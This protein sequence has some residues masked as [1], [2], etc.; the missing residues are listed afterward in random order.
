MLGDR[1]PHKPSLRYIFGSE[2]LFG[3][4]GP[5]VGEVRLPTLPA[6]GIEGCASAHTN[7]HPVKKRETKP[8]RPR[9]CYT[10]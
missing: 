7:T 2:A 3:I 4:V 6:L 10:Q 1:P 9:Q 5:S 8:R